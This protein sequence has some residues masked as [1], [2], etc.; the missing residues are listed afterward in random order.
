MG[1]S[2]LDTKLAY[3]TKTAAD[4]LDLSPRTLQDWRLD[5]T[6]PAYTRTSA[7]RVLYRHEDLVAWL[8]SQQRI[9]GAA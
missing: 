9:G 6:G 5:G 8:D 2:A 1:N 4:L 7:N 3:N